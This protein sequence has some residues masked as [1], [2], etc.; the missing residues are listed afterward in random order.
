MSLRKGGSPE[1]LKVTLTISGQGS[2]DKLNVVYHNRKRTEYEAFMAQPDITFGAVIPYIIKEWDT[3]FPI[4]QEGIN[5]FED[6]YPGIIQILMAGFGKA[7]QKELEK[8]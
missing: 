2:T 3:D 1:T 7:R 8:N 5:E 4:T 6:E